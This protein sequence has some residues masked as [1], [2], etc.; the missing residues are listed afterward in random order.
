MQQSGAGEMVT[1]PL[2][3]YTPR[4]HVCLPGT[5]D[6]FG[7]HLLDTVSHG[8]TTPLAKTLLWVGAGLTGLRRALAP[9]QSQKGREHSDARQS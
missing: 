9:H 1:G 8:S 6:G 4:H 3:H 2:W 7:I 5:L